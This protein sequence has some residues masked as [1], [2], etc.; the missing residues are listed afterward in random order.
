MQNTWFK[1]WK[2]ILLQALIE[3]PAVEQK[4]FIVLCESL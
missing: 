2:N 3:L 1:K 4:C